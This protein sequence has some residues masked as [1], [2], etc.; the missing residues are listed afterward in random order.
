MIDQAPAH[1]DEEKKEILNEKTTD[2]VQEQVIGQNDRESD[3]INYQA[4]ESAVQDCQIV[5]HGPQIQGE[6]YLTQLDAHDLKIDVGVQHS[7]LGELQMQ[8]NTISVDING[9]AENDPL[10]EQDHSNE[11]ANS[12]KEIN[13]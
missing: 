6:Q 7:E 11:E 13:Q 5:D 3:D 12:H 9:Q 2:G 1:Q 10:K 4:D 8:T